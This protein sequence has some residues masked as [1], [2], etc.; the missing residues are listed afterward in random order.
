[1]DKMTLT[2]RFTGGHG[3]G[4]DRRGK[5]DKEKSPIRT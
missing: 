5:S 3:S 4:K 1:M 2:F